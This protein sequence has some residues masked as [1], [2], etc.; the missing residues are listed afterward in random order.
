MILG[1]RSKDTSTK[2]FDAYEF[3]SMELWDEK[4]KGDW[5]FIAENTDGNQN[6]DI[7]GLD[8][9]IRGTGNDQY[10]EEEDSSRFL[11]KIF[12]LILKYSY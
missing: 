1:T 11:A 3:L 9:V 8:V 12:K 5:S 4:A 7:A 2:G 10:K 6:P